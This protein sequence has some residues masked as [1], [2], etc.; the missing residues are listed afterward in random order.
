MEEVFKTVFHELIYKFKKPWNEVSFVLYFIFVIGI[1][2]GLGVILLFFQETDN[3]LLDI[4]R[5]LLTYSIALLVPALIS[6]LAQQLPS[7][8]KKLSLIIIIVT[9]LVLEGIMVYWCYFSDA[10]LA[11]II[12]TL[13]AWFFWVV[14][15]SDNI[16]L[17]DKTYDSDIRKKASKLSEHW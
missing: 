6:M 16:Y 5:N 15:N 10:L 13:L 7:S 14:V 11:S 4:S 3:I 9:I 2:G 8:K 17:K 12:S 1:F